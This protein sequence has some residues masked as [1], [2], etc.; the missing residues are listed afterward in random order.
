VNPDRWVVV[1]GVVSAVL[2]VGGTVWYSLE[3][4]APT[5]PAAVAV[6]DVPTTTLAPAPARVTRPV[7][8]ATP[9][10][11]PPGAEPTPS[12][13]ATPESTP[14]PT[15]VAVAS[16]PA[17]ALTPTPAPVAVATP[18]PT[19]PTPP[20]ISHLTPPTLARRPRVLVDVHGG[21]FR[22]DHRALILRKGQPVR[23]PRVARQKLVS[24][25]VIQLLLTMDDK[26]D[27]GEYSLLLVGQDGV[28]SNAILFQLTK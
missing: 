22:A 28:R 8:A 9:S 10:P 2:I 27:T 12:P 5:P 25:E 3:S 6:T 1:V 20:G 11:Q 17:L 23:S 4:P 14:A 19:P 15:P 7:A 24:S 26:T 16:R 18:E 13:L 21:W